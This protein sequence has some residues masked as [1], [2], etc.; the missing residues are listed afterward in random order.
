MQV[1]Q[2]HLGYIITNDDSIIQPWNLVHAPADRV[3]VFEGTG[4]SALSGPGSMCCSWSSDPRFGDA[5]AVRASRGYRLRDVLMQ[6]R[7]G[8]SPTGTIGYLIDTVYVPGSVAADVSRVLMLHAYSGTMVEIAIPTALAAVAPLV[9]LYALQTAYLWQSSRGG[10]T[11]VWHL[12]W[13]AFHPIKLS[14]A[15]R[16]NFVWREFQRAYSLGLLHQPPRALI[17]PDGKSLLPPGE[18]KKVRFF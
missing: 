5:A 6:S 3:W 2:G 14:Q 11:D 18:R 12:S 16:Q 10:Y 13:D 1:A 9:S 8:G 17:G 15:A 4:A 7:N